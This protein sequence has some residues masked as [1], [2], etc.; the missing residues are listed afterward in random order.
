MQHTPAQI[1]ESLGFCV[2]LGQPFL[3]LQTQ[4][5]FPTD[6]SQLTGKLLLESDSYKFSHTIAVSELI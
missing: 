1:K 3:L 6:C 2:W 4:Q 5:C